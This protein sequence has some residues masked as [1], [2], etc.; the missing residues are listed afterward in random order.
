MS[1]VFR[2]KLW[3]DSGIPEELRKYCDDHNTTI[4]AFANEAIAEKLRKMDVHTM[5]IAE[6]EEAERG[7]NNCEQ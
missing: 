2:V 7:W 4:N 1:K 5:T 3:N 6:I